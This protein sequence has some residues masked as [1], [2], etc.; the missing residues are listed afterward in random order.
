VLRWG[1]ILL[2]ICLCM[3]CMAQEQEVTSGV[4]VPVTVSGLLIHTNATRTDDGLET[5]TRPAIR[6]VFTPTVRLGSH[7][8]FYSAIAVDS[9]T[10]YNGTSSNYDEKLFSSDLMQ[11][12]VGYEGHT[13]A[14]SWLLKA[15]RL[16]SAF[17]LMPVEY[18][19]AR[20]P[21]VRPAPIYTSALMLRAD[22][23]PCGSADL[24]RQRNG[25]S[26]D[27]GCGGSEAESYGITP[28][29]LYGLPGIEMQISSGRVD[30]RFQVT[31]SSPANPQG[32]LS[33]NQHVQ[34]TAGGGFTF[35]GG[36]HVGM[37]GFRGPYL[38]DAIAPLLPAHE[39]INKLDASGLGADA[40]WS[41]G[42]WAMEGEWQRFRFALPSFAETPAVDAGFIQAKATLVPRVFI[43]A[44]IS[45]ERFGSVRDSLGEYARAFESPRTAMEAS[46][47]YRLNRAQV[48]KAG[49]EFSDFLSAGLPRDGG[50][51]NT[52]EIELVTSM[53]PI[54]KAFR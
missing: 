35:R 4:A 49:F 7:L 30:G 43:A 14:T 21:F 47:G 27:F 1:S 34:W 29:T 50:M 45:A 25:G 48:I 3:P 28:V 37:S 23:L 13:G 53:A 38:D 20:M 22:Q 52:L 26:I 18:D 11:A 41:R 44:R 16:N 2:A 17:G 39:G 10:Y 9:A 12:F 42:R 40:Q 8:F 15:G 31:N 6:A 24:L 33:S 36:L 54:S 5:S 51:R 19:D 32:L 46:V